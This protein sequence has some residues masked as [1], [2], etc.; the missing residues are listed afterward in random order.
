MDEGTDPKVAR[1]LRIAEFYSADVT[2][3]FPGLYAAEDITE[4]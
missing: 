4:Y 3:A 1:A 2:K